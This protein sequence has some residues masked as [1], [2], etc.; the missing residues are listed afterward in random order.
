MRAI[1]KQK[2][3][4]NLGTARSGE[5]KIHRLSGHIQWHLC[6]IHN[7]RIPSLVTNR[8]DWQMTYTKQTQPPTLLTMTK[9]SFKQTGASSESK[10]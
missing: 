3:L 8:K 2:L 7:Y 6:L 1:S 5:Q 4:L 9:L 10:P